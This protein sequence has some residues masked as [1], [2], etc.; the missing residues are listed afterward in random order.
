MRSSELAR[1]RWSTAPPECCAGPVG[2][3]HWRIAG[4]AASVIEVNWKFQRTL[5]GQ[6]PLTAVAA[7]TVL[8]LVTY[9]T[10]LATLPPTA[11]D[12]GSG[13]VANAWILSA[14]SVGLAGT[15]LAAGVLGDRLG[16][17]QVYLAGLWAVIL[18]A[19]LAAGAWNPWVYVVAKLVQGAGGAAVLACGLAVLAHHHPSGTA[20]LHATGVWG[21]SVGGGVAGGSLLAAALDFGT[22]WRENYVATVVV[23]LVVLAFSVWRIPE[24]RA[25]TPRRI[26]GVGL[27]LLSSGLVLT[28]S[29]L[30]EARTGL[31]APVM[32]LGGAAVALFVTMG[33][34][35]RRVKQPLID[36]HL[37]RHPRFLATTLGALVLGM[38]M[39]GMAAFLPTVAQV[40]YGESLRVASLA[41]MGWAVASVIAA[42]LGRH[43]PFSL[44]GGGAIAALL[45]ITALSMLTALWADSSMELIVPLTLAGV[46]TGLL[47]AMLGREAVASVPPDQAAMASGANNTARYVGASCGITL[48]AMIATYT[49][50]DITAGWGNAVLVAAALTL[51][52][53]FVIALL[54]V[55]GRRRERDDQDAVTD[56]ALGGPVIR[57]DRGKPTVT[58]PDRE[59]Q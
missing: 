59:H 50:S 39:I 12:L 55:V 17:R 10:P 52:G 42:M 41:P 2:F 56:R 31:G 19:G 57:T 45:A 38:G 8:V 22:A 51:A 18:G 4:G 14:M 32:V 47:N 25:V 7:G 16:R 9:V 48:F 46:T 21:A 1:S 54:H 27:L 15:L 36:P 3:T 6:D 33:I 58:A 20:R 13:P 30:T 11:R 24:S 43:L 40:G 26:D 23:G 29:V 44:S 35:E 28:V 5:R 37:L 53:A 49:G 34:V